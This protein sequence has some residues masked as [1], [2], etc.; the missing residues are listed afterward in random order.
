MI[1][2]KGSLKRAVAAFY[3][4]ALQI[5][6][7]VCP[8]LRQGRPDGSA[9]SGHPCFVLICADF[10]AVLFNKKEL[11]QLVQ[12]L[13]LVPLYSPGVSFSC[14]LKTTAKYELSGKPVSTAISPIVFGE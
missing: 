5:D 3:T 11:L 8:Y 2:E 9:L 14:F 4:N 12:Q 6:F 7:N 10:F 1:D 13:Y